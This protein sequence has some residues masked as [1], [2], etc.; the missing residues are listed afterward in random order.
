MLRRSLGEQSFTAPAW[1][2][3]RPVNTQ[4]ALGL[5]SSERPFDRLRAA[6]ALRH[7]AVSSSDRDA[8]NAALGVESDAWVRLALS[9]VTSPEREVSIASKSAD[10]AI[11]D[12]SQF[13]HDVRAQT[14]QELT[15]MVTHELEPLLGALRTSCAEMGD[16]EGGK[17]QRAIASVESFLNA[18]RGLHRASGV[19]RV[20]DF[21]LSDVVLESIRTVLGERR[22]RG[23]EDL[24]AEVGRKDHVTALG[25]RDLVRLCLVNILRNALEASDPAEGGLG[26]PVTVNWGVT[27]TDVWVAVF[28]RGIGLPLGAAGMV[29]PGVTT[30]HRGT[31]S[32]MGLAVCVRALEGMDG[33]L[34]HR[35]RDGG[36][37][38]AEMRWRVE[39]PTNARAAG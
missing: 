36:G 24:G 37:V 18:L 8:I 39:E 15:A 16:F 2:G 25:D 26:L 34:R 17:P 33:T 11:E 4:E 5:L 21:S 22:Q 13:A 31:H 10:Q 19:P 30:K 6:R 32:G 3:N 38:V 7:L 28:D 20:S 27:D 14:T 23:A 35:P 9:K 12:G 1:V 29:K